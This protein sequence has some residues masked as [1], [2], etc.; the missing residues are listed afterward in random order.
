MKTLSLLIVVIQLGF[1]VAAKAYEPTTIET[2]HGKK[3]L[4]CKIIK[5][6]PDGVSFTHSRGTAK[7]LFSEMSEP[8]RNALGYDARKEDDYEK[9]RLES[10][11]EAEQARR[12]RDAKMAEAMAA[13]QAKYAAQQPVVYVQQANGGYMRSLAPVLGLGQIGNG[14]YGSGHFQGHHGYGGFQQRGWSPTV[15][16]I[17]AG[18]GGV[19]VPQGHGL[20][21]Y[22][23]PGVNWSPTLG[24]TNVNNNMPV[25]F[26][27][28]G[29]S[30]TS[31]GV[32][33]GVGIPGHTS[34][35]AHHH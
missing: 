7:V 22:G 18:S 29:Q 34:L 20:N 6:D 24:Y 35:P 14:F 11:K 28:L 5:R 10:R 27:P 23:F 12:A 26:G 4:Q 8:M 33:P 21:F 15:S 17:G 13:A 3:Y 16:S 25:I 19:Y 30:S 1:V 31:A 32:V 2:A 9:A